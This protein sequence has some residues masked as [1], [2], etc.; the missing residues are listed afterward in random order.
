MR[1]TAVGSVGQIYG[2]QHT[3]NYSGRQSDQVNKNHVSVG[4]GAGRRGH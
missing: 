3:G 2:P 1:D 4:L